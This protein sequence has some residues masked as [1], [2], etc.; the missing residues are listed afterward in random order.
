PAKEGEAG[1]IAR[2]KNGKNVQVAGLRITATCAREGATSFS[3]PNHLPP[4]SGSTELKPVML[5]PGRAKF[6]TKRCPTGAKT[7]T[8]TSGTVRVACCR[9]AV[10]GEL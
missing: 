5:P 3:N 7:S 4:I 10:T 6:E 1:S 8:N 2:K 9:A